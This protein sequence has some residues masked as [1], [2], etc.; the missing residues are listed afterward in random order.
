MSWLSFCNSFCRTDLKFCSCSDDT[1][2]KVWDFARC[3]EGRSLSGNVTK[4]YCKIV[5]LLLYSQHGAP[6][7]FHITLVMRIRMIRFK[8]DLWWSCL[9]L[10]APF[11]GYR[12]FKF[13]EFFRTYEKKK[14]AIHLKCQCRNLLG[15]SS[16]CT[17]LTAYILL[18][19]QYFN[20]LVMSNIMF[21]EIDSLFSVWL[22]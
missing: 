5:S 9:N 12:Y 16:S 6:L 21:M 2:V 19:G 11:V 14:I 1:T 4:L 22:I 7:P 20:R 15:V 8:F 13:L 18:L 17:K 3:Q 10:S